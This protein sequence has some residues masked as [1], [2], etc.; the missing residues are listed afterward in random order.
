ME[1]VSFEDIYT[2][3][4]IVAENDLY[5][6]FHYPEM[7]VRY[8]SNF[9]EFK[10]LPTLPEFKP[11]EKYLREYHQKN[12]QKHVKFY[13]PANQKPTTELN[14][15]LTDEGY[16]IGFIELFAIL[17]K[18]FPALTN[19]P[20]IQIEAV[21]EKNVELYLALQY[22]H[23]LEYGSEF[24]KQ[25]KDL[26]KR[27]FKEPHILQVLAYY[28]GNPAGYVDIIISS[29]TAEIDNLAVEEEFRNK[30]IASRLQKFVMER[31]PEKTVILIADGEDTPRE[32]YKKQN[33]QYC[34][35]KYEA[36]K[37]YQD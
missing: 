24:A 19:N 23:D 16:E 29:E 11:V 14:A 12:G 25:K 2:L 35:F 21:T 20:D 31:F 5:R 37:V 27:Q 6:H 18:D 28:K 4:K 34:G 33:Y 26:I 3:G 17:P 13:F 22:K 15:Y 9:I 1:K 7:L 10:K 32:M 36:Q 30:G 8:D